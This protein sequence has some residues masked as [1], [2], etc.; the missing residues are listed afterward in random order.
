MS[1][2]AIVIVVRG[3]AGDEKEEKEFFNR[4][5]LILNRSTNL[6]SFIINQVDIN[7]IL[8]NIATNKFH[9]DKSQISSVRLHRFC[10]LNKK[11]TLKRV[12]YFRMNLSVTLRLIYL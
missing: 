2:A 10:K 6:Y 8:A 12:L 3:A 7:F 9:N 5:E 4:L 11:G 1:S